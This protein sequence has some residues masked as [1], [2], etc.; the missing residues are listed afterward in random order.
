MS[1]NFRDPRAA[2]GAIAERHPGLKKPTLKRYPWSRLHSDLLDDIRWPLVARRAQAPLPI[3]EALI[4]RLELHANRSQ[5]RGYVGDFNAEAMAVRWGVDIDTVLRVS[6]ELQRPDIGWIDQE[7][8]V[9]FWARNPDGDQD[10]TAAERQSRKR[11]RDRATKAAIIQGGAAAGIRPKH[12]RPLTPAE[13]KQRQRD[14]DRLARVT[15]NVTKSHEN[16]VT[17]HASR[18]A[19][20]TEK[21]PTPQSDNLSRRD[22]VTSRPE[23]SRIVEEAVTPLAANF[24]P[25]DAVVFEDRVRALQWLKGD[26]E[27]LVTSRL[28][29]FRSR[30]SK[31]LEGWSKILCGDVTT[32]A[33]CVYAALATNAQGETFRKLVELQVARRVTE[34]IAPSLPLGPVQVGK[35]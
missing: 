24:T 28:G 26:G 19:S 33:K 20:V 13:R 6:A 16:G 3:V 18:D 29:G 32:L 2:I 5:P 9:T 35:G 31:Q 4:M 22:S 14:R 17:R 8:V 1:G 7:H 12:A 21:T 30:A 23:Q 10:A 34:L 15:Q 11:E 27:A 25:I